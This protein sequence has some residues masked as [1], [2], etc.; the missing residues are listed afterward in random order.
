[1]PVNRISL[2]LKVTIFSIVLLIGFLFFMTVF[3]NYQVSSFATTGI[4]YGSYANP[5]YGMNVNSFSMDMNAQKQIIILNIDFAYNSVG[6]YTVLMTLPYRIDSFQ[7]LSS[8]NLYLKSTPSG[9]IAMFTYNMKNIS[10]SGYTFETASAQLHIN[11][12]ILDKVFE[13]CTINLPFGGSVT[14]EV[15]KELDNFRKISPF[16]LIGA[17][18][19]GTVSIAVPYSAIITETTQQINRRDPENDFQVLEFNINEF[20]PFRLQYIDSAQRRDF[21][22]YLLISGVMFGVAASGFA[23]IAVELISTKYQHVSVEKK[24]KP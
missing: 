21:E 6:N 12:S 17:G 3:S 23:E 16:T 20:K 2:F 18:I 10:N 11:G 7:N 24:K 4:I 19:S 5:D 15:S 8:G 22:A 1:M 9:S 14:D 13:T